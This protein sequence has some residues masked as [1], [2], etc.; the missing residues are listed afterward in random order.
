METNFNFSVPIESQ[1]G[2]H[3]ID[4]DAL[5]STIKE[6]KFTVSKDNKELEQLLLVFGTL[7][8]IRS[9][10]FAS[11]LNF[12]F[13]VLEKF[14]FTAQDVDR[15]VVDQRENLQCCITNLFLFKYTLVIPKQTI[16][17]L[18]IPLKKQF[19]SELSIH[20]ENG[21]K[22]IKEKAFFIWQDYLII[23]KSYDME[24]KIQDARFFQHTNRVIDDTPNLDYWLPSVFSEA[25]FEG[26][27]SFLKE[28]LMVAK[29]HNKYKK[30]VFHSLYDGIIHKN[31]DQITKKVFVVLG[32]VEE[33]DAKKIAA[34]FIPEK[35]L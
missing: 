1:N 3:L 35:S 31:V 24:L 16:K 13:N 17:A 28:K 4:A 33:Q 19:T 22:K 15:L 20:G 27:G 25:Q 34:T 6:I 18:K 32:H 11:C 10:N 7:E 14:V 2:M 9:L 5:V 26:L 29:I 8:K 21:L 23:H 30:G 12:N